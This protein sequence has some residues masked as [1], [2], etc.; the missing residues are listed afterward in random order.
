MG[1]A[2]SRV[3]QELVVQPNIDFR[4]VVAGR[5]QQLRPPI[6]E[7][8]YRIAREALVNAFR[9]SQAKCVELELEYADVDL[10]MWVRDDGCGIDP[11]VL[12]SGRQGHWGLAGMHERAEKIGARLKIGTPATAGTEVELS[13]PN[14]IA[15]EHQPS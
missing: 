2:L 3:Q 1:V 9:H 14:H 11:Q 5:Q 6:Q 13:V 4:V 12:D 15:F 7:E 8:I 10:R